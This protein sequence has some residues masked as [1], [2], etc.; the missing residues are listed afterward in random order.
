MSVRQV[1]NKIW[2][3]PIAFKILFGFVVAIPV[4]FYLGESAAPLDYLGVIFIRLIKLVMVCLIFGII[5]NTIADFDKMGSQ[6]IGRGLMC[7]FVFFISL[8]IVTALL[9]IFI[10]DIFNVGGGVAAKMGVMEEIPEIVPPSIEDFIAKFV[11]DNPITPFATFDVLQVLIIASIF[12]ACTLSLKKHS[13]TKKFGEFLS[14]FFEAF[15]HVSTL[16]LQGV[17]LYAPIGVFGLTANVV[18]MYKGA[19]LGE[20]A[21]FVLYEIL[22]LLIVLFVVHPIFLLLFRFPIVDFYK[23]SWKP[24]VT[25]FS[26]RSSAA[27]LPISILSAKEMKIKDWVSSILLPLGA[28]IDMQGTAVDIAMCTMFAVNFG[29]MDLTM[30]QIITVVI[31]AVAFAAGL[32]PAPG[33]GGVLTPAIAAS[34]GAPIAPTLMVAPLFYLLDPLVTTVNVAGDLVTTAAVDK[35]TGAGIVSTETEKSSNLDV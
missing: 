8:S 15:R 28:V 5:T 14:T 24:M 35:I 2:N 20:F 16:M 3:V 18:G 26:T 6:K 30:W 4:G 7:G 1:V 12:G 13:H 9:T 21:S 29:G 27:T 31:M 23:S 33:V 10:A 25:A 34:I 17:L 11:P 19:I 32:A 22:I